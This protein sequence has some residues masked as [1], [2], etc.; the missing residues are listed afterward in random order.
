MR[1]IGTDLN[2]HAPIVIVGATGFIGS[3][4]LETLIGQNNRDIRVLVHRQDYVVE[5]GKKTVTVVQGNLLDPRSLEGLIVPGCTVV[6]SAYI[7]NG[8]VDENI[9]A[10]VN[11]A[12]ACVNGGARRLIHCSTAIFRGRHMTG[13]IDETADCI[14]LGEYETAKIQTEE[15]LQRKFKGHLELFILRPTA[16]FAPG[17]KNLTKI[18]DKLH[19]GNQASNYLRSCINHK[20]HLNLV[21]LPNVVAAIEF[22]IRH[23]GPGSDPVYIIADDECS[24]N[25]YR[26]VE[27]ILLQE[28]GKPKYSLPLFCFPHIFIRFICRL[29]RFFGVQITFLDH[30]YSSEK[31]SNEGFQKKAAFIDSLNSFAAWHLK[32]Q[33]G[34]S[35]R[36][37]TQDSIQDVESF[38]PV[39]S[40]RRIVHGSVWAVCGRI[41][42]TVGGFAVNIF[43]ARLLSMEEMGAYF[44]TL[45]VSLFFAVFAQ[46]GLNISVVRFIAE[47]LG[48]DDYGM[49]A[50]TVK[51]IIKIGSIGVLV[52]GSI[53]CLGGNKWI[54]LSVFDSPLMS[55]VAWV[56]GIWVVVL[57]LQH[58]LGEIFRGFHDIRFASLFGGMGTAVFSGF[59]SL[60]YG[61]FPVPAACCRRLQYPS[62]LPLRML[63]SH[64]YLFTEKPPHITTVKKRSSPVPK[65]SGS[66]GRFGRSTS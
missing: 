45:S 27:R 12:E 64:F 66:H 6:N 5:S 20:R 3:S 14:P 49:A 32:N 43:L 2:R 15:I 44:L 57:A 23:P 59:Y 65:F 60:R 17:G 1:D 24:K 58:L 52:V 8:T 18:A 33:E 61:F 25:N 9:Q 55:R 38:P 37:S 39:S 34:Q 62:G 26:F 36:N 29:L 10:V 28:F 56:S 35:V 21:S 47:A 13:R 11:L 63:S 19:N 50:Q 42:T 54:A 40:S 16:V 41:L 51:K 48:S 4:L 46:F 22:M 30:C 31:I 7:Q 53:L